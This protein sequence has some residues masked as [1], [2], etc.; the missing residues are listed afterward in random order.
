MSLCNNKDLASERGRKKLVL[1]LSDRKEECPV[2][3]ILSTEKGRKEG[4]ERGRD[5]W[6][7]SRRGKGKVEGGGGRRSRSHCSHTLQR[8]IETHIGPLL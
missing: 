1:L 8:D 2:V 5:G 7:R 6:R 4:R 3:S